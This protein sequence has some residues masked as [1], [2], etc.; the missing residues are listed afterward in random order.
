MREGDW[1]VGWGCATATYPTNI[2]AAAARLSLTP[3]GKARVQLAAH[4]IGTG[5]Y[6]L[7]AITAAQ[8]LGLRVEDI[9]VDLGDSDLPPVPVAG[10]SNNAAST[11]HVVHKACEEARARLAVAAVAA[12][13]S[14][15]SGADPAALKLENAM[16]VGPSGASEPLAKAMSRVTN[17]VLEIHAE[18]AP[19]GSPPDALQ[20]LY[21]GQ[22]SMVRGGRALPRNAP[23][24]RRP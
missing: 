13:D 14:P 21:Q 5:A 3:E 10:G 8:T 12:K 6:T 16:L 19:A 24:R 4:E 18:N 22:M 20:K 23:R 15:F 7:V 9:H 17:G 1:L 2:G 11:S